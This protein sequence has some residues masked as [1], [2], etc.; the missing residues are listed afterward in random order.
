MAEHR[1]RAVLQMLDGSPVAEVARRF[2]VSRQTVYTWVER[3]HAGG[4]GGLVDRSRRPHSSPH[5]VAPEVEALVC[6]L[7]RTHPRWGARRIAYDLGQRGLKPVPGRSTV[8]RILVRNGLIN[9]QEQNHRRV[10]KRWQRDAPMQLWQLDLMS[11]VFLAG[12]R[13]CKLVTGIDDH[14]RFI[15]IAKVVAQPSGR[16]VCTAFA[17]AMTTYG[18]PPEVLTDNGK[19]FTGRFT[20]P[21]PAEVLFERIC[22]ENGITA[23]LTKPRSPTTTGKIERF[24]KSLRRELLDHVGPFADQGTA[25]AA[26]DAWV[27]GY[28]H[29]RPHQALQM[30][31]PASAFRPAD[32]KNQQRE[33][34]LPEPED[35]RTSAAELLAPQLPSLLPSPR[36]P[37]DE[38]HIR[39][40][41]FEAVISPIGRL[42]LPNNQQMKFPAALGGRTATIW[43]DE[44][45]IHVFIDGVLARTRPSKLTAA[46][47]KALVLRGGSIAGPEPAAPALVDEAKP[48]LVVEVDRVIDRDGDI[49]LGGQK[50]KIAHH[51]AGQP[52]TLRFESQLMHVIV[53]GRVIKTMPAPIPPEKRRQI[54]GARSPRTMVIPPSAQT[55]RTRRKVPPDGRVMLGGQRL[56]I[57]RAHAGKTVMI[58]L[59][60]TCFRVLDGDVELSTHPRTSDKPITGFRAPNRTES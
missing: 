55:L 4:L 39:A 48:A 45:S 29:K 16:A 25:Q 6:E 19:Q 46:D 3:Y 60:D 1:Y 5:Q 34:H 41:Q 15:V 43:A 52:A 23:R 26:I 31:T 30:A 17:E 59:E 58:V 51:L 8:H 27:H 33:V 42:C 35:T 50:V 56:R 53:D 47:L 57:G 24:H 20:K 38:S 13:E 12:G 32:T 40:V 37:V 18:V 7:R 36:L 54:S 49:G 11:G 10:Y 44:R 9:H 28:N 21:F 2:G 14:S 22:R